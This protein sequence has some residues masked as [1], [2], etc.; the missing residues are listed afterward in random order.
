MNCN[1]KSRDSSNP[2]LQEEVNCDPLIRGRY[3]AIALE[4]TATLAVCEILV[5]SA[6]K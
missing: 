2:S 4:G 3:V 5:Y 1:L 6:G